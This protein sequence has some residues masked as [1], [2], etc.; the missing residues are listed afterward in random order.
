MYPSHPK[1]PLTNSPSQP[2]SV[3]SIEIPFGSFEEVQSLI[4]PDQ[5]ESLALQFQRANM[6]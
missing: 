3:L 6:G 2:A 5:D 1:L 4:K